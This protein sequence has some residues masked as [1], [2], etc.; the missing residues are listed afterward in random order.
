MAQ[1][2]KNRLVSDQCNENLTTIKR[3]KEELN[4][5]RK[6]TD[7]HASHFSLVENYIEKYHP[8]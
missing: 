6:D 7:N 2:D 4:I 3:F 8:V 1:E 5:L